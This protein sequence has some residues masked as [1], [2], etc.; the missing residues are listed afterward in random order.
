[1]VYHH[2]DI[3][4]DYNMTLPTYIHVPLTE[5]FLL[6][7]QYMYAVSSHLNSNFIND[8]YSLNLIPISTVNSC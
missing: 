3:T 8:Y 1:M 4:I 2:H 7:S 5:I 6:S